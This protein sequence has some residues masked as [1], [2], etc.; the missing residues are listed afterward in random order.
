MQDQEGNYKVEQFNI[1]RT[2]LYEPIQD[3]AAPKLHLDKSHSIVLYQVVLKK[4]TF[5]D[6][7]L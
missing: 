5:T 4:L 7:H 3:S 6:I 2:K 1:N